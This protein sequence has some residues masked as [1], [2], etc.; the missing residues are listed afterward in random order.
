MILVVDRANGPLSAH[1]TILRR[2][3]PVLR[4][5][6]SA[7]DALKQLSVEHA[8][9]IVF[10]F[11]LAEMTAPEFCR[12]LRDDDRTRAVSLLFVAERNSTDGVDLCMAAGCNDILIQPFKPEELDAKIRK[13]A[14]VPTRGELRTLTK[15]EVSLNTGSY[16]QLGHSINISAS[17]MLLEMDHVL[18]PEAK[19]RVQ[20]YLRGDNVPV[21]VKSQVVRAEFSGATPRYGLRFLG[22]EDGDRARVERFVTR[23]RSRELN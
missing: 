12:L 3:D 8:R 1:G 18:P 6:T 14:N 22:M 19:V 4:T 13:L 11:D 2:E 23:L 5:Y 20:F 21:R 7:H 17:G 9:L 16:F 10:T 15:V